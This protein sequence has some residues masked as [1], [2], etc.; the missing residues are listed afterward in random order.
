[1]AKLG[2]VLFIGLCVAH[3]AAAQPQAQNPFFALC[4]DTHDSAKRTLPQ[5]AALLAELGYDGAGHLWLDDLDQR[6][7]TL[8]A[9]GL[10]LFQVY[11][12]VDLRP[13]KTSYDGRL[14]DVL[15]RLKDRGVML[16][17]LVSGLP[18]SDPSGDD[19]AVEIVREIADLAAPFGVRVALYPHSGDWLERTDDGLRVIRKADR[20]NVGVMFNLCHWLKAG[21]EDDPNALLARAIPHLMAVTLN[22]ADSAAEIRAG[23][24]QWIQPLGNGSFDLAALLKRLR[25]LGYTGPVGLQCYGITGDARKHL[26]QSI[27]AWRVLSAAEK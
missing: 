26:T 14:G 13:G 27:A 1:M 5:Q 6:L 7:A 3:A 2:S 20:P 16:T 22:G 9:V 8:D 24:G 12:R 19:R 17:L 21:K 4:M 11:L 15:P 25:S 23:A 18:P 10:D